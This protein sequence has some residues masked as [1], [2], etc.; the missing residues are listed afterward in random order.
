MLRREEAPLQQLAGE[1]RLCAARAAAVATEQK[2]VATSTVTAPAVSATVSDIDCM[3]GRLM[4]QQE[5][6]EA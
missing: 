3:G 5:A 6:A 4:R 1:S 2:A